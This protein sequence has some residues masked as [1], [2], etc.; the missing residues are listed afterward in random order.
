MEKCDDDDDAFGKLTHVHRRWLAPVMLKDR[1]WHLLSY[2]RHFISQNNGHYQRQREEYGND[3]KKFVNLCKIIQREM[4]KCHY[5]GIGV[6]KFVQ[7]I[8]SG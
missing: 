3:D 6:H 4:S 2:R 7:A 8:E 1:E 5:I